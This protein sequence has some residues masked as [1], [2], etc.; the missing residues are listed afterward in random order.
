MKR[1]ER[2]GQVRATTSCLLA[3]KHMPK[4]NPAQNRLSQFK[5]TDRNNYNVVR[6]QETTG[7]ML[8]WMQK[9]QA[10]TSFSFATL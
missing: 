6:E 1:A 5:I 4:P 7:E 9:K 3:R 10:I 2:N 8:D